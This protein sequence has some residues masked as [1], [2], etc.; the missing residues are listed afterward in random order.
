MA[1]GTIVVAHNSGGPKL[2]I[3]VPYGGVATGFLA[4]GEDDYANTMAYI[5]SLSE[6]E[7]L[8]IRGSA[9]ASVGRFSD[10]VFDEEFLASV[11]Q[12]FK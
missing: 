5:L 12:L 4:E 10:R 8:R 11:K 7:R 1:A 9:R 3:V 6:K 2:D